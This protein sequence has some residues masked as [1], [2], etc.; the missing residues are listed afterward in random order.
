MILRNPLFTKSYVTLGADEVRIF[1]STI[2]LIIQGATVISCWR[3]V[4]PVGAAA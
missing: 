4:T 3:D 1:L 2:N